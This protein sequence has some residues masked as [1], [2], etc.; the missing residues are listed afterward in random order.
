MVQLTAAETLAAIIAEFRA[1]SGTL[2]RMG[3]AG[4]LE[5]EAAQGIPDAVLAVIGR[6]P[7]GKG[8]AGLAAERRIP[9]TICNLQTDASGDAR[10]GARATGMEGAIAVPLLRDG[11]VV[12]VLGIANRE[13]RTF[14]EAEIARLAELGAALRW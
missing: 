2:H 6:I 4:V 9:V 11:A 5:L 8:M 7:V 1:D 3:A 10:P 14:T 12:G 13:P